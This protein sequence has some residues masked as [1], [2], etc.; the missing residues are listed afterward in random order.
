M[1]GESGWTNMGIVVKAAIRA[2]NEVSAE[3]EVDTKIALH[4]ADPVQC[5]MVV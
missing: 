3:S 2:V 4:V 1:S 5:G